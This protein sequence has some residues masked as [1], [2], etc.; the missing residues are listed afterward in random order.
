[1]IL[2]ILLSENFKI[3]KKQKLFFENYFFLTLIQLVNTFFNFL[4]YPF[5]IKVFG[6]SDFGS[7]IFSSTIVSYL[8]LFISFGLDLPAVKILSQNVDDKKI[9]SDLLSDIISAKVFL[10][11]FSLGIL[12][13]LTKI[14]PEISELLL[15]NSIQS[16]SSIF[17]LN[18]YFQGIQ[19]TRWFAVFQLIIRMLSIFIIFSIVKTSKDLVLYTYIIS[20]STFLIALIS[21]LYL[22][23]K[24]NVQIRIVG[25]K[26]IFKL[27]IDSYHFFLNSSIS[28]IR[29]QSTNIFVGSYLGMNNVSYYDLASK[30]V[31]LPQSIVSNINSALFPKIIKN[32]NIGIR[33]IK[34]ILIV[35]SIIGVI[36]IS[37]VVFFGKYIVSIFLNHNIEIVHDLSIIMSITI[38]SWLLVGCIVNFVFI[39]KGRYDLI[40]KNQVVAF[41]SFFAFCFGSLYFLKSSYLIA[42]GTAVS[43]L[44]EIVFC[45]IATL[46]LN[47]LKEDNSRL[48]VE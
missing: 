1:M 23:Y 6:A 27:L 3:I 21:F 37:L 35:E 40:T 22:L 5:S 25:I 2:K 36:L 42:I 7:Y 33:I 15:I 26:R 39:P 19:K 12:V 11:F 13:S 20:I 48:F 47:L 44:S 31:L 32:R 46:R 43:A 41:V 28:V 16:F 8:T 34:K 9:K 38:L 14:L 4:I 29:I 10:S 17:L 45:F 30:I 24:E 18:W